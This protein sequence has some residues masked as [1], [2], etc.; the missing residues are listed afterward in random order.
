MRSLLTQLSLL[1]CKRK[2]WVS[3]VVLQVFSI[4]LLLKQFQ[5]SDFSFTFGRK[6][7]NRTMFHSVI[8]F[9]RFFLL[10]EAR[11]KSKNMQEVDVVCVKPLYQ[12]IHWGGLYPMFRIPSRISAPCQIAVQA[13]EIEIKTNEK[14]IF[15]H[16]PMFKSLQI[17]RKHYLQ[18]YII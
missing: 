10:I 2:R 8:Y 1:A 7:K 18:I 17:D 16:I 14:K 9:G 13:T 6:R 15:K 11:D 12:A 4:V 5:G 3:E